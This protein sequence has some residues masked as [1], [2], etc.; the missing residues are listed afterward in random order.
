MRH[1][2]S[3]HSRKSPAVGGEEAL[4]VAAALA[5]QRRLAED[6]DVIAGHHAQAA[7]AEHAVDVGGRHGLL[8]SASMN[9]LAG[10]VV[11]RVER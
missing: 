1:S 2:R 9:G 7:A 11:S 8:L 4:G 10:R 3:V 5:R 6:L